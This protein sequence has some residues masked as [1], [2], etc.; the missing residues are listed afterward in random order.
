MIDIMGYLMSY[1][2]IIENAVWRT[3][4]NVEGEGE[5]EG[6]GDVDVGGGGRRRIHFGRKRGMK[7][8]RRGKA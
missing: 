6:E 1:H 4:E 2:R 7:R 3:R 8:M 5:G